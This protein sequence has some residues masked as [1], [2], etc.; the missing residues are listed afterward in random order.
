MGHSLAL[1]LYLLLAER[2]G[3]GTVPERPVRPDGPLIW[4]HAGQGSRPE[5]LRQLTRLVNRERPGM[6]IVV[7]RDQGDAPSI[8]QPPVLADRLP[9]DR[10]AEVRGFLDHW[11]P[12]L[13]LFVGVT[14]PPAL[15]TEAHQRG[16]PLILAE[17]HLEPAMIP[18]W[19]RGLA[20]SVL[21]RFTRVL[22]QDSDTV[23]ALQRMG[24]RS[25]AVE[26]GGRIEETI[27]PLP[28]VNAERDALAELLR[29]RPVWMAVACTPA[30]EDA[31]IVAHIH[32]MQHAHRLLLILAPSDADRGQ[33]LA[34]K[35]ATE[36]LIA[37]QRALEE[38]PQPEVQVMIAEGL[39]ELGLWYRL[40]PVCFMGGTL[41]AGGV[42]GRT[43]FE[44][45]ALGS[46][47]LHG[48]NPG[49]HREAYARL[50]E[51]RATRQVAS[52]AALATAVADLIA[53]DKAAVLAHNAWAATSGGTEVAE[54]V[55][56]IALSTLD[57]ANGKTVA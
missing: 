7:T 33:K 28:C 47:I 15:I 18:V 17:A 41:F 23:T 4:M 34:Q 29:A 49:P 37:A 3:P 52:P 24:G 39:T 1:S 27:D 19:R 20:G 26:L 46:A 45:A 31:V 35:L 16:I 32:A 50:S 21:G 48:P 13:A 53:P 51:A 43:P 8:S 22:A 40:A 57:A 44:P 5:S 12:S 30:E 2:G 56:Q 36:G 25:L 11:R 38:D 9:D 10:L 42:G 6:G 55:V 14:L 54:R